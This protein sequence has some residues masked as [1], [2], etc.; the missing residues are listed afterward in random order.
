VYH[1]VNR[2]SNNTRNDGVNLLRMIVNALLSRFGSKDSDWL[3]TN[4]R[5]VF[6]GREHDN[7]VVTRRATTRSM[8]HDHIC[9]LRLVDIHTRQ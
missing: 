6:S 9:R 7:D 8:R 5:R 2:A 1:T 3:D 4:N